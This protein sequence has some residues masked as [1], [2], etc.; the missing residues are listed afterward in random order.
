[1]PQAMADAPPIQGE[2]QVQIMAVLWRLEAGTVEQIREGLPARYGGAYTTVQ[3]VLNRLVDR[4]LLTRTRSGRSF[5]YAPKL[6]EA[7]YLSRSI[8]RTF[9]GA[10]SD[11]RQAAL[12]QF[13][14]ALRDDELSELK[15][16][17]RR[18]SEARKADDG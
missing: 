12:A 11:A 7:E 4:G 6:T 8:A 17:T 10:S 3:T 13:V 9:A 16:L 5:T 18:V 2:L 1:M 15:R 14:G